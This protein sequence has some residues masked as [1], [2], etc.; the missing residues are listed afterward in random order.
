MA[1]SVY[2]QLIRKW[3]SHTDQDRGR[4]W[5][6]FITALEAEPREGD[7]LQ[8][9]SGFSHPVVGLGVDNARKRLVVVSGEADPRVASLAQ[10]DIQASM[11]DIQVVMARPVIL[12]LAAAARTIEAWFGEL[13]LTRHKLERYQKQPE[14]LKKRSE[15]LLKRY[16]PRVMRA[17]VQGNAVAALD[18]LTL[19]KELLHQIRFVEFHPGPDLEEAHFTLRD[20]HSIV[21]LGNIVAIDPVEYDREMGICS[22]P[23][24]EFDNHSIEVFHEGTDIEA[25]RTILKR[26]GIFQY[27]FPPPDHL[28][29]GMIDPAPHD[30]PKLLEDVARVPSI[31]HPLGISEIVEPGLDIATTVHAL[32][33][34]GFVVEGEIG[35]ELSESG[36]TVRS[37]VK[38]SP[39]E[40]LFSEIARIF[41]IKVDLSLKDLFK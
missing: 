9:Q 27:F 14:M 5:R 40:S 8:G 33:E 4:F 38:F 24:Y 28:A 39:R 41:H 11:P 22:V 1:G 34:Q 29:L 12:S 13:G 17:L 2:K 23:L 32:K 35:L 3:K 16:A 18:D 26:Y 20:R 15:R 21:D 25:A 19:Y 31:G 7:G 10:T 30:F 37:T 6:T 36:R